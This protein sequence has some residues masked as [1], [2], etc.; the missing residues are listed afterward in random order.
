MT[1][2]PEF[3]CPQCKGDLNRSEAAYECRACNRRYPIVRGIPDFRVFPDP[4][5][6]YE[7]D[8][9]K[10][11]YVADHAGDQGFEAML[12]LYWKMTP[13]VSAD[14]AERFVR[15]ALALADKGRAHLREIES[16]HG[17]LGERTVLEIGCGTGGFLIAAR[18]G[19]DRV[20]GVDI[21]FRWLLTARKRLDEAGLD[22]PLV[23]CCAEALPFRDGGFDLIVAEDA[24]EHIQ[25][26]AAALRECHRVSRDRGL[27]FLAAINRFSLAPE[28]HVRVW[29]VGFLP[30]R[31]MKAYVRL[32]RGISYDFIRVLSRGELTGLLRGSSY[33]DAQIVIPGVPEAEAR[34]FP[35]LE[36]KLVAIYEWVRQTPV[37]RQSLSFFGPFFHAL[38]YARKPQR[39][40]SE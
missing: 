18:E 34:T 13:H 12:R 28:P 15:N 4:Y 37:L 3:C 23:C 20:V 11:G 35:P 36:R 25:D 29:G 19:F 9:N 6:D 24:I 5:I 8:Y 14:R 39:C 26:Q 32:V 22:V 33:A 7:A 16:L 21:A 2:D 10:G 17:P 27:L 40:E 1:F 31:W 30:R 38:A